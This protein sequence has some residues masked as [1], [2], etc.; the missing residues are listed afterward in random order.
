VQIKT[1]QTCLR[2]IKPGDPKWNIIDGMFVAPRAG[3][4]ISLNCP[5][6]YKMI[7]SEC[8]NYGWL[9]PVAIVK[10]HELFWEEFSK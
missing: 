4:E 1:T 2:T 10:D 5:K 3:F 6:E 9:K 7:I 8:I